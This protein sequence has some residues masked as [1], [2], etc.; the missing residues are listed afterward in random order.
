MP[1]ATYFFK[2]SSAEIINK[3]LLMASPSQLWFLIMLF[4][5]FVFFELGG[6]R[7]KISFRN[8]F[9]IFIITVV[10]GNALSAVGFNYFQLA[11][12]V[13]YICIFI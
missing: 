3:Y 5:V 13:K 4:V 12:A 2:Y 11:T 8:L 6:N 10:V 9:L 7:I 1:I